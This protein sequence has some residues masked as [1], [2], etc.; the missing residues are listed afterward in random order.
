MKN[1]DITTL[2][3]Q[4]DNVR[5]AE[6]HDNTVRYIVSADKGDV[7]E[8]FYFKKQPGE[9]RLFIDNFPGTKKEYSTSIPFESVKEFEDKLLFLGLVLVSEERRTSTGSSIG[10]SHW[11]NTLIARHLHMDEFLKDQERIDKIEKIKIQ[12]WA[13]DL[14]ASS[15]ELIRGF[16]FI[17]K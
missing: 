8:I 13:I 2:D 4:Y 17:N 7:G 6:S 9:I 11:F 1:F 16:K 3:Q 15:K 5:I 12:E 10:S 14:Y